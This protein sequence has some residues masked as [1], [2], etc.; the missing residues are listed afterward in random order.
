MNGC[1]TATLEYWIESSILFAKLVDGAGHEI[2]LGSAS[3]Q[4]TNFDKAAI[5][6]LFGPDN[7]SFREKEPGV[8]NIIVVN[9]ETK[10]ATYLT[11]FGILGFLESRP[12]RWI[13][14]SGIFNSFA[15]IYRQR[16]EIESTERRKKELDLQ[17]AKSQFYMSERLSIS[18]GVMREEI[19]YM[20]K[21]Y[22]TPPYS[23]LS[24]EEI[25][26][27]SNSI[28]SRENLNLRKYQTQHG[29]RKFSQSMLHRFIID[30]LQN[31]GF[32]KHGINFY[33]NYS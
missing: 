2:H 17:L 12:E 21:N 18:D 8:Q 7:E 3:V 14:P 15:Q 24:M 28:M 19:D 26:K 25:A 31:R 1:Q 9:Q 30:D 27:C 10:Q 5:K 16:M 6:I 32:V 11:N 33:Q 29:A 4:D 13:R 20:I 23:R 22:S